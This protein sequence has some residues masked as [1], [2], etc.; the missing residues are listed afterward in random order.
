MIR[1][2]RNNKNQNIS[3]GRWVLWGVLL[4][5]LVILNYWYLN[6]YLSFNSS[7]ITDFIAP[8]DSLAEY[9]N[10]AVAGIFYSET[11]EQ[12]N[13]NELP[14]YFSFGKE[15][16]PKIF[17]VPFTENLVSAATLGKVYALL[18]KTAPAIKN[19]IIIAPEEKENKEIVYVPNQSKLSD[20]YSKLDIN[21]KIVSQ[22][23]SENSFYAA[24]NF[25]KMQ[26]K[27][28][29]QLP[30]IYKAM[31][32]VKIIPLSYG[33][34]APEKIS[35]SIKKYLRRSDT[36]VIIPADLSCNEENN[37]QKKDEC[38]TTGI[39]VAL[40]LSKEN[41]YHLQVFDLASRGERT[42]DYNRWVS[43]PDSKDHHPLKKM[44]QD[45]ENMESFV[46]F[47]G[48]DLWL[49]AHT[50]FEKATSGRREFS[51]SRRSFPEDVFN[52]GAS[53]VYIF[54]DD[55]Q[56]GFS[57]NIL[58]NMS[59]AQSI[60]SNAYNAARNLTPRAPAEEINRISLKIYLL[61][62]FEAIKYKGEH[63]LLQ[64][65]QKEK[66]GLVIQDGNRQGVFL[67]FMWQQAA[68]ERDFLRKL[69]VSAGLNPNYWNSRI[70]VYRFRTVEVKYEN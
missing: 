20:K 29:E 16:K 3:L 66:D 55:K 67:P 19:I 37:Q 9:R 43:Y 40:V 45:V 52:R 60:A 49:I 50:A 56:I 53:Y 38:G 54:K 34:I 59:V 4:V 62:N 6:K 11:T 36:I 14:G 44:D 23:K 12:R 30:F 15:Y 22:L 31:P 57:G 21:N 47:Y 26:Y 35:E 39:N 8:E 70:K 48:N 2:K 13:T 64:K 58:P 1:S 18:Q 63:D 46:K 65:I 5:A 28:Y 10:P 51:P 7:Y 61:S 32:N 69:K 41:N 27:I 68:D 17:V 25:A 42:F 33:K 24:K